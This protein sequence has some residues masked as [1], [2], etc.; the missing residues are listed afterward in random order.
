MEQEKI[1]KFILKLRK[2]KN[3]TQQELADKIGVTD[4]AISKWENGRGMPDFSLIKP[5]CKELGITVNDLI[6]GEKIEEENYQEKLEENIL[7]TIDY[8]NKK[9]KKNK[10]VFKIII[11][12]IIILILLLITIFLIDVRMMN[13]NKPVLFS[14]WGFKY[15][16]AIDLKEEEIKLS[17]KKYLVEKGESEIKNI[18]TFVSMKVYLIEE[19][20]KSYHIYAWVRE[21]SYYLDK[22]QLKEYSSSS[23]PYKFTVENINDE[24]I[25]TDYKIPR[26]GSY[27]ASD[28]KKIFPR[29][30]RRDMDKVYTDGTIQILGMEIEEQIKLY[31]HK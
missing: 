21:G 31:F 15:M 9:I 3:M 11:G 22:E 2:E 28:M 27:Y 8:T 20:N 23:I 14:T 30:V 24:F 16:P 26:D 19:K 7:N 13:Q 4:R 5:L 1:G 12:T 17:I 18:K 25:V 6:S 29:S 10:N